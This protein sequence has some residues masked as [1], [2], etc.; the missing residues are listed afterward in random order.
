MTRRLKP[1]G[2]IARRAVICL[3]AIVIGSA[4]SA[5]LISP[6]NFTAANIAA[7]I[8]RFQGAIWLVYFCLSAIRGITLLPSTPLVL[9][10]TLLFPAHPWPVLIVSLIGIFLSSSMIYFGSEFLGFDEYF[11]AR[12]PVLVHRIRRRLE[13]PL[14][15]LFVG[16][17]AFFPLVPT[18][19]VC[20]VAGT[21]RMNFPKFIAAVMAGEALLCSIYI[22]SGRAALNY[23]H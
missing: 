5:Y 14:G 1:I 9:A 6:T 16:A 2:R 23:L 17:W 21:S 11:E 8:E 13:H 20:Y 10:G 12:K 18:D 7:F 19:A 22:F 3:W 4:I 15:L